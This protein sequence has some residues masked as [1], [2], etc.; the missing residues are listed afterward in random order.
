MHRIVPLFLLCP[1]MFLCSVTL[2]AAGQPKGDAGLS[3]QQ[4]MRAAYGN[5]G[6]KNTSTFAYKEETI[7]VTPLHFAHVS[8]E[9]G[10]KALLVTNEILSEEYSCHFCA[11]LLGFFVF[12]KAGGRW[13]LSVSSKDFVRAG[14]WGGP[15]LAVDFVKIGPSSWALAI[16]DGFSDAGGAIEHSI[17]LYRPDANGIHQ[18]F[19]AITL[20][21]YTQ[22]CVF[23][24]EKQ[25]NE[26]EGLENCILDETELFILPSVG[27]L[28]DLKAVK[29]DIIGTK[30]AGW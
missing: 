9:N 11:P 29:T 30:G 6:E 14:H 19:K 2:A 23:A 4:A 27:Q 16:Y 15:P 12:E 25:G 1:V 10:D 20:E 8:R 13:K 22:S 3:I 21:D 7:T 17:A 18:I 26:N 24:G 28:Y 5:V